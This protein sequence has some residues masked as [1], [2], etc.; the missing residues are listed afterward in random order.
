LALLNYHFVVNGQNSGFTKIQ[1]FLEV[2]LQPPEHCLE[3]GVQLSSLQAAVLKDENG[4]D[5]AAMRAC[6][7]MALARA[8]NV[9]DCS[10]GGGGG[11]KHIE[12]GGVRQAL[13]SQCVFVCQ[14]QGTELFIVMALCAFP[15]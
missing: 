1:N 13:L 10:I 6:C 12:D 11:G 4:T 3:E 2:V 14:L 9:P 5:A 8:T 7:R 15:S